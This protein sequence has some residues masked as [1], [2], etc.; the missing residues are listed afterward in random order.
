VNKKDALAFDFLAFVGVAREQRGQI[1]Q[2]TN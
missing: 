1:H 2:Q